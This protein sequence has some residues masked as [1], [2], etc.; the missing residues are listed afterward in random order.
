MDARTALVHMLC[1]LLAL[2]AAA[3]LSAPAD[4]PR[5]R[6]WL[7]GALFVLGVGELYVV[8]L[9]IGLTLMWPALHI[10]GVLWLLLP[11]LLWRHFSEG[12][13]PARPAPS[14]RLRQA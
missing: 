8:A 12:G 10:L 11:A 2:V 7:C 13:S 4:D 3:A 9:G 1:A 6:P 14:L 5:A